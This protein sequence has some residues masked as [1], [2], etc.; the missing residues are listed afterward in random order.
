MSTSGVNS[1][2]MLE[3]PYTEVLVISFKS[4]KPF[5]SRSILRV[6]RFSTSA[7]LVP[8]YGVIT[9]TNGIFTSG[10]DSRGR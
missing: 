6:I 5:S 9:S 10:D 2:K 3:A 4:G 8:L 7:G 1:S